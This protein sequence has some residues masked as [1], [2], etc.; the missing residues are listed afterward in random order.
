MAITDDDAADLPRRFQER[1]MSSSPSPVASSGRGAALGVA[2]TLRARIIAG[3]YA[4]GQRLIEADLS[5]ELAASRGAVRAALVDLG[6]EGLV[7]RIANRG[8]RVRTVSAAEA[9][10]ITEVRMAVEGLCAAKAAERITDEEIAELREIG[11]S[12]KRAVA[13]GE[14]LRYS[15][16]NQLLHNRVREISAQPVAAEVLTRLRA[17]NVRHQFRLALRPGRPQVSLPEHLAIIDEIC[18]RSA[19]GAE[20]AMRRHL[21]SVIDALQVPPV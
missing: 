7:E 21:A 19:D 13:D 10:A 2:A 11:R 1:A 16:L 20:R 5:A 15:E 9:V 14:V 18:A 17:Q 4:P 3:D 6:H 8:A 12:M